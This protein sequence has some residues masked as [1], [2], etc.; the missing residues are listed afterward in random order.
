MVKQSPL[1]APKSRPIIRIGQS[2]V[3]YAKPITD[4]PVRLQYQQG[5]SRV[6]YV[7]PGMN[8]EVDNPIWH[9]AGPWGSANQYGDW[10]LDIADGL[11][12]DGEP[13]ALIEY[14]VGNTPLSYW[15]PNLT[16]SQYPTISTWIKARY[17]E[18]TLPLDPILIIQ[19]S[20]SGSGYG[21]TW[22]ENMINLAAAYRSLLNTPDMGIVVV[23]N[24]ENSAMGVVFIAYQEGYVSG[25]SRSRLAY[26]KEPTYDNTD[27]PH[28]V[29]WDASS[30]R[31]LAI[32]PD[33][34]NMVRSVLT[35][36]RELK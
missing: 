34:T 1:P 15:T 22:T 14:C 21:G 35:C 28:S 6:H 36:I 33:S 2:N 23:R 16:D 17:D 24:A 4:Y 5:V 7:A 26:V 9:R 19:Q 10:G 25:D 18:L 31:R 8:A 11:L 20:E 13:I 27:I 32:G 29:H 12:G 30:S 3:K